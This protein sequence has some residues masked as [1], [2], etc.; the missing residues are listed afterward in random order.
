MDELF[1]DFY[2][3]FFTELLDAVYEV[4]ICETEAMYD[5]VD[6]EYMDFYQFFKEAV[7]EQGRIHFCI[8]DGNDECDVEYYADPKKLMFVAYTDDGQPYRAVQFDSEEEMLDIIRGLE[9][10]EMYELVA[11]DGEAEELG[12]WQDKPIIKYE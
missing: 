1:D 12:L 9:P 8:F 3:D 6:V 7:D 11:L 5:E 2:D 10:N 4:Y